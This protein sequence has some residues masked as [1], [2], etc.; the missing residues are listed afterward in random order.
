[1]DFLH[2]DRVDFSEY[3][4][5]SIWDMM[6]A[7]AVLTEDRSRIEFQVRIRRED[8]PDNER[9]AVNRCVF[10]AGLENSAA[11]VVVDPARR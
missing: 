3:A 9:S 5:S 7:P 11:D 2:S 1:M 8:G 4:P 6:D 10:T